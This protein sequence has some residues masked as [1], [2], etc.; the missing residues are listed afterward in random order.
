MSDDTELSQVVRE[1][2]GD[3]AR[4]V[5]SA[6]ALPLAAEGGC[7]TPAVGTINS[8]CGGAAFDG[9]T[10]PITSN[11]YVNGEIDEL[12]E[13]AARVARLRQSR[14]RSRSSTR[15]RPCSTSA[16][17]AASMCCSR[18]SALARQGKAYG[19]DM[20]DEMLALANENSAEAGV[21]NVEFLKGE[22]ENIPLPDHRS[23]SSSRTA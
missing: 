16:P 20:T 1:K 21:E 10:D 3:A 17:A 7:C 6:T 2:Y 18:R 14:R 11:L 15:A 12:P 19:L 5:L 9:Q 8:C 22:I 13:A 23:T 4:R